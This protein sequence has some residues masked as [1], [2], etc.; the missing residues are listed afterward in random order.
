[1]EL[2]VLVALLALI[3][4]KIAQGKGRSFVGW[5]VFGLLFLIVALPASLII[6]RRGRVCPLCAE[7]IQA[8]ASVCPH[9]RHD[10]PAIVAA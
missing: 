5:W 6:K 2:L 10:V 7:P 3:P 4:A 8:A 1:M 9:C